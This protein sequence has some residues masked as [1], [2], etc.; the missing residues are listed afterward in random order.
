MELMFV[1]AGATGRYQV[2]DTHFH[3]SLKDYAR[4]LATLWYA[5][6]MK[7]LNQ[8]RRNETSS[9]STEDYQ[10][11][12]SKLMSV[13]IFRNKAPEWLW[14]P[15][16]YISKKIPDEDRNLIKTGWD[17]IYRVPMGA[18]GFLSR[19]QEAR[20]GW[21]EGH[22]QAKSKDR[23]QTL[24]DYIVKHDTLNGFDMDKDY[25]KGYP[26]EDVLRGLEETVQTLEST[27]HAG[28][29]WTVWMHLV[30]D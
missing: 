6:R 30:C 7:A 9:I 17:E 25:T 18:E 23:D 11:R 2:N 22:K 15:V 1:P 24:K 16:Q 13:V 5:A 29:L 4:K 3:K 21:Q 20:T 19:A 28:Y 12:V 8:M 14:L 10:S 27:F 26:Q